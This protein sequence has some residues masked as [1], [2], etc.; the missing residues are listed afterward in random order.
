MPAVRGGVALRAVLLLVLLGAIAWTGAA[1]MIDAVAERRATRIPPGAETSRQVAALF[2]QAA[3]A[4]LLRLDPE[5]LRLRLPPRDLVE[6]LRLLERGA[7]DPVARY[8]DEALG[9]RDEAA[10]RPLLAA[11]WQ[12]G[13]SAGG[14]VRVALAGW[15]RLGA[16][17]ALREDA[18]GTGPAGRHVWS[19]HE[20]VERGGL[21]LADPV[22]TRPGLDH[23]RFAHFGADADGV[24]AP[25]GDWLSARGGHAGGDGRV[26]FSR[27]VA[28][29]EAPVIDVLGLDPLVALDG[30]PV[31]ARAI[32]LCADAATPRLDGTFARSL[33]AADC[34]HSAEDWSHRLVLPRLGRAGRLSVTFG[35]YRAPPPTLAAFA[36]APA[37]ARRVEMVR[38]PCFGA[39]EATGGGPRARETFARCARARGFGVYPDGAPV[40]MACRHVGIG[41][42][43]CALA[44][45]PSPEVSGETPPRP[46]TIVGADGA[47]LAEPRGTDA[48]PDGALEGPLDLGLAPL[49]GLA[50]DDRDGLYWAMARAADGR[51]VARLGIDAGMQ[52]AVHEQVR[53]FAEGEGLDAAEGRVAFVLID[54]GRACT[55]PGRI[56]CAPDHGRGALR[57]A[58]AWPSPD[59]GRGIWN[60]RALRVWRSAESSLTPFAW[61]SLGAPSTPGS[62]FKTV[63]A[64]AAIREATRRAARHGPRAGALAG[65]AIEG[66]GA[67]D[68]GIASGRAAD[69]AVRGRDAVGTRGGLDALL[70][71]VEDLGSLRRHAGLAEGVALAQGFV[72]LPL[73]YARAGRASCARDRPLAKG[74]GRVCNDNDMPLVRG[75]V[76]CPGYEGRPRAGLCEA[77]ARSVNN[78]FIALALAALGPSMRGDG[79]VSVAREDRAEPE[80]GETPLALMAAR[81]FPEGRAPLWPHEGRP[82]GWRYTRWA[83]EGVVAFE[84]R[85]ADRPAAERDTLDLY[86]LGQNAIGQ[87]LQVNPLAIAGLY[88]GVATGCVVEPVAVEV[89]AP[90][91]PLFFD[92]RPD[93]E[94]RA[95][96]TMRALLRPG[97][98]AVVSDPGG[99]AYA[100]LGDRPYAAAMFAKTGTAQIGAERRSLWMGGWVEAGAVPGT[101]R[102]LAFACA[103]MDVREGS[104]GR[105]CGAL[106]ARV[107]DALTGHA[108]DDG[109]PA[110]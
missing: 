106:T 70:H 47:L 79:A 50:P 48:A 72:D 84:T 26:V 33:D 8:W 102:P 95:V 25:R 92:D 96:E 5:T 93:L 24:A 99:T 91:R 105:T 42:A 3:H 44:W 46:P 73:R 78:Y 20:R 45:L 65:G 43:R 7:V 89:R 101:T 108:P 54:A 52:R 74:A 82:V 76:T 66:G 107:F 103:V 49:L 80:R 31:A 98:K 16:I 55:R 28:A 51:A 68:S 83:R 110:R 58:A 39:A 2:V 71:G 38:L 37:A 17:A 12:G 61:Q 22:A 67:T 97:L 13:E 36:A 40:M 15:N 64:L 109:V 10:L 63:T 30:V 62:V 59:P 94:A 32:A 57:V 86:L 35:P 69:G 18:R 81:L 27:P 53:A 23:T 104:G 100:A 14:V 6:R 88:A 75:V 87:N 34:A 11:L 56:G 41:H 29:G 77:T 60:L 21:T 9:A 1:R 90:C 19:A 4:G 85:R